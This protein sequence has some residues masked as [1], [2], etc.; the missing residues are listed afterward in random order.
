[1]AYPFSKILYTLSSIKISHNHN[2]SPLPHLALDSALLQRD[3][4]SL[5]STMEV[6]YPFESPQ[7][8]VVIA[9]GTQLILF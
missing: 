9:R 8:F 2:G 5:I 3:H 7:I 1:M 4:H 6:Q